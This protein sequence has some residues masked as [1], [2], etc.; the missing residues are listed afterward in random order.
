M[1]VSVRAHADADDAKS[2]T[3]SLGV[4]SWA[5]CFVREDERCEFHGVRL[6]FGCSII[7]TTGQ[8]VR[9]LRDRAHAGSVGFLGEQRL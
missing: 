5:N 6:R 4:V 2:A 8:A 7:L 1:C 3:R 9:M